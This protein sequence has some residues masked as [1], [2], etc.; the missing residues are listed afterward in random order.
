MDTFGGVLVIYVNTKQL[1][2]LMVD[3]LLY[4]KG[5]LQGLATTFAQS[6]NMC[7]F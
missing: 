4:S 2:S 1:N 3:R 6:Q 7:V 5:L